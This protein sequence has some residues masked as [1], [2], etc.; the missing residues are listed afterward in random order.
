MNN[1]SELKSLRKER[2]ADILAS[3]PEFTIYPNPVASNLNVNINFPYRL[4]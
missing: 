1:L 2:I 3:K 4:L